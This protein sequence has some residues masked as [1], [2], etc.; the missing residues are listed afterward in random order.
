MASGAPLLEARSVSRHFGALAAVSEVSLTVQRGERWAVIGPNG[1]GKTTLFRVIAGEHSP[2]GGSISLFGSD[3][4][5]ANEQRRAR[6]GLARTYQVSNLFAELTAEQNVVLAAQSHHSRRFQFW[7][8][9][10]LRGDIRDIVDH[11]LEQTALVHARKRTVKQ[12]SH[13]EQRQLELAVA[14]AQRPKLLLLDE[15]AA[16]LSASERVV[17]R[18]LVEALPADLGVILIEHDMPLALGLVQKVLVMDNGK[19]VASGTPEEI[20]ANELVQSIYLKS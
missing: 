11:S 19:P 3:V 12:L 6:A 18:D 5:R 2:T 4:I 15:P 17:M 14:L 10:R 20:R 1:A 9:P 16:G 7:R 8:S 13:G